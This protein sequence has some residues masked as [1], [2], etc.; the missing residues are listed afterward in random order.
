MIFLIPPTERR[1]DVAYRYKPVIIIDLSS[2][3]LS[4]VIVSA[5]LGTHGYVQFKEM[6]IMTFSLHCV[7]VDVVDLVERGK[8]KNSVDD[9]LVP[10]I[11]F[12][13]VCISCLVI[14]CS[15]NDRFIEC[16]S[17]DEA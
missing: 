17:I 12:S 1:L 8:Q 15:Q 3:L 9:S 4:M 14:L 7:L 13:R 5:S 11:Q 2:W 6:T 10:M 16:K